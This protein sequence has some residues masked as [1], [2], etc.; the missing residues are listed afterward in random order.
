MPRPL[1]LLL[2]LS[3]ACASSP[4]PQRDGETAALAMAVRRLEPRRGFHGRATKVYF[5]KLAGP[6]DAA[7]ASELLE[8]NFVQGQVCALLNAEPGTYAAVAAREEKDGRGF[9][10]FFPL[11]LIEKTVVEV[12]P[13]EAAWMGQAALHAQ[14]A[15]HGQDAAQR[16]YRTLLEPDW[17]KMTAAMRLFG[18]KA[19]L[20]GTDFTYQ[21]EEA[22][23]REHALDLFADAGWPVS[24]GSR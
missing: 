22:G 14:A 23:A 9:I 7:G 13:G 17:S 21:R 1:L 5:A 4:P 3:A 11:A 10:V 24:G 8:S 16:H 19:Y 18:R 15:A 2:A 6:S 12:G 20:I